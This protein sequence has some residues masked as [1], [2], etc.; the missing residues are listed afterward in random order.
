M[1]TVG[2]NTPGMTCDWELK[3]VAVW[4]LT[5]LTWGSVFLADAP[6]F[7]VPHKVLAITGGDGNGNATK[8]EPA[9]GWTD[10][11]L[12]TVFATRSK[13]AVSGNSSAGNTTS[14]TT[15]SGNT[16]SSPNSKSKTNI[17]AI[18][19]GVVG[20]IG[21]LAVI[22][23]IAFCLRRRY[24]KRNM[25]HELADNTVPA[26]DAS[27]FPKDKYELP[28]IN[29]ND[30]AELY[31]HEIKELETPRWAVEADH[32]SLPR[33]A[34]LPGTSTVP[35]AMPGVPIV[36][37]PGDDLPVQPEY[38][39]GLRRPSRERNNSAAAT[40]NEEQLERSKDAD[41]N[42]NGEKDSGEEKSRD[43]NAKE[44]H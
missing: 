18:A 36:R 32:S 20:G 16:S 23:F 13:N 22:A 25:A 15:S 40:S 38:V 24:R 17:G 30:P 10:Q 7:Q 8:H 3:G 26:S 33:G 19:G 14:G 21:G 41:D 6:D 27:Y 39:P 5:A 11:G 44:Q 4:D 29:E 1:I 2:G 28:A 9:L 12:K 34:E 31:G 37:T 35:G 42:V 43:E